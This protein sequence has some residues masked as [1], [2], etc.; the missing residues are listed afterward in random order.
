MVELFLLRLAFILDLLLFGL[1]LLL[2]L[3]YHT[4]FS[5]QREGEF[6]DL[7]LLTEN[8]FPK[9]LLL[10]GGILYLLIERF[11]FSLGLDLIHLLL[12]DLSLVF[13]I[14]ETDSQASHFALCL[15]ELGI[16]FNIQF[17]QSIQHLGFG[18]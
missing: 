15:F 5:L 9:L 17:L 13:R 1:Q 6:L 7:L 4:L 8:F 18:R 3:I 16:F 10:F 14:C 12:V 2:L 11:I